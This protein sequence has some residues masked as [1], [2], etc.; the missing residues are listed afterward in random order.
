VRL[1]FYTGNFY[2]EKA[3][4]QKYDAVHVDIFLGLEGG[5][6]TKNST[7]GAR[8]QKPEGAL[9][10]IWQLRRS[11]AVGNSHSIADG[12]FDTSPGSLT[13]YVRDKPASWLA[14]GHPAPPA[15][16][17][18]LRRG[19]VPRKC[20]LVER[21]AAPLVFVEG[22][23]PGVSVPPA[24]FSNKRLFFPGGLLHKQGPRGAAELI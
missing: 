2:S 13:M 6:T 4:K 15:C 11:S 12:I 5:G 24:A 23:G 19:A 1:A 9:Q 7:L 20:L 3:K 21:A 8:L 17:P 14:T 16:R 22:Q 10:D 18:D